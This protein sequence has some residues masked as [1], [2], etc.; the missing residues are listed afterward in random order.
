MARTLFI[1]AATG[2]TI[3]TRK[4]HAREC[5]PA[6][7]VMV[8]TRKDPDDTQGVPPAPAVMLRKEQRQ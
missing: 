1:P 4:R 3:S 7:A 8:A 2:H 5:Y 6:P